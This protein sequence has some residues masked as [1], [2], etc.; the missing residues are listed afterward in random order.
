MK[1]SFILFVVLLL[2]AI[3]TTATTNARL[4]EQKDAVVLTE[5]VVYGDKSVVEG[6]TVERNIKY[7]S[8]MQWKTVYEVGEVS[9]C[10]TAYEFS[11][12]GDLIDRSERTYGIDVYANRARNISRVE[13]MDE[14]F[15]LEIAYKELL[16]ET[17]PGEEAHKIISLA[18]YQDYYTVD[19]EFDLPGFMISTSYMDAVEIRYSLEHDNLNETN[20]KNLEKQLKLIETFHEIIK[21]PVLK[22]HIYR[23]GVGKD[24]EGRLYRWGYSSLNGGGSTNGMDMPFDELPADIDGFYFVFL[25]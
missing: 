15:G 21:I 25:L 6:V 5:K 10:Y 7:D 11:A 22:N 14:L 23:I 1:K 9:N 4:L 3:A 20:R 12:S 18:D 8:H 24:L 16:D 19:L 2:F 13:E 17:E